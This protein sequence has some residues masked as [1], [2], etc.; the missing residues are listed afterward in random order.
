MYWIEEILLQSWLVL[1]EMAPWLLLG[2]LMAGVLSV[3]ISPAWVERHLGGRG[4]GSVVKA[5]VF[6]VP[7]PLCSC[8]VIPVAASIYR[9]GAS[10]SA[11]T[12]FL[13]STPQTGVDSI[14]VTYALLGGLF[15]IFRPIAALL[16]GVIGGLLVQLFGRSKTENGVQEQE[17]PACTEP[18]CQDGGSRNI[19]LRIL[20][21][22]LIVLPRDIGMPLLLGVLIAGI[23]AA[24][25]PKDR[26]ADYVAPGILSILLMMVL[27]V[28]LYVCAT[29]SVPIA[30]GFIHAGASPGAAL[31]F[32]IAGPATNA[33]AFTTI[34]KLLGRRTAAIYLATVAGSAL[35][36]G[37]ILDGLIGPEG[38]N[39]P[40]LGHSAH[41][42]AGSGWLGNAAAVALL[43]VLAVSSKTAAR[44]IGRKKE[45]TPPSEVL[46]GRQ[47]IELRITGMTCSHC[48][49][50]V[51]R[52]LREQSGVETIEVELD[53]GRAVVTGRRLDPPQ[54]AAAVA[55]LG[56]AAKVAGT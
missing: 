11:T 20:H 46:G 50:S 21:Y 55:E 14:A 51:H 43:V 36:C 42:M 13:I 12:S 40:A 7:L 41:E 23:L 32:L 4:L 29:A 25:V 19:V 22:G 30:A 6:G 10:R 35:A 17:T 1:G 3:C 37:L 5:A 33:A 52:A 47:R 34:W 54:L 56:Y 18:C 49:E 39:I 26:L 8:G 2:F 28:P 15:A 9:H 16:T 45:E 38:M 53:T 24:V 31:A 48:A 44:L 27:G